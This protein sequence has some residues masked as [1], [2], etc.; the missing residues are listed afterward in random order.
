[1]KSHARLV[2]LLAASPWG[3]GCAVPGLLSEAGLYVDIVDKTLA[4][5]AVAY[6]P[7]F[8]LWSDGAEKSRW[9]VI[10][11]G[12]VIDT[13]S[14]DAWVFPVGTQF[15][16]EFRRD[17]RRVETRLLEKDPGGWRAASYVWN[18]DESEAVLAPFFGQANVRGTAHDVPL[19]PDC[20]FCH[21]DAERPLGFTAMQ[22][23]HDGDGITLAD[24]VAEGRVSDAPEGRLILPGSPV[25]Q[26]AL[27]VLH[28]NCG[29]CHAETGSQAD[30][31]LRF[32]LTTDALG[33][34][35]DTPAHRS[36]VGERT[37]DPIEGLST[38][39]APGDP[40]ASLVLLRMSHRGD[41]VQMPPVGT[42]EVDEGG[43][44]AV[45]AW[46]EAMP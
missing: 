36:A 37:D 19:R 44:A 29:G 6:T 28:A 40:D 3:T 43:L 34:V 7:R 41:D 38:Y 46:V 26:T 4:P 33:T 23:D 1:M 13:S 45:R 25:E 9:V 2:L 42:E 21:G 24:L 14:M 22:L 30:L 5:G 31:P 18:A 32:R 17:G 20:A 10:P 11:E 15:F 8:V 35:E 27:G 39:L 16:K 12:A